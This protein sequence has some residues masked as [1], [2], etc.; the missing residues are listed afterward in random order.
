MDMSDEMVDDWINNSGLTKEECAMIQP[1]YG[2]PPC[3]G[4]NKVWVCRTSNCVTE[5]KCVPINNV[6][7]W[8]ASGHPCGVNGNDKLTI[9]SNG[10][11]FLSTEQPQ[12]GS[13]EIFDMTGRLVKTIADK[14]LDEGI[15]EF[16]LNTNDMNPGIYLLRME[17]EG[18]LQ[19]RKFIVM[20]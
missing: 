9:V 12:K 20:K 1:T 15:D 3:N 2:P 5:C 17:S 7:K 10:D 16:N 18:I 4:G 8:Q 6:A 14:N 13:L 19:T 11:L